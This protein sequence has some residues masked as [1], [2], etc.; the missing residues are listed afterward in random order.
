MKS[1]SRRDERKEI[2]FLKIVIV[3]TV[4]PDLLKNSHP[5]RQNTSHPTNRRR[6][7]R[8]VTHSHYGK[9]GDTIGHCR[10]LYQFGRDH[11]W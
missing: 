8:W 2:Q 7:R 11:P 10:G 4:K 1:Q 5:F 3:M 6:D 9:R